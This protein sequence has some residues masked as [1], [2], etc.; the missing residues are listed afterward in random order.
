MIV[1]VCVEIVVVKG[2]MLLLDVVVVAIMF[3][4]QL[5]VNF[6]PV[7]RSKSHIE[8]INPP[9]QNKAINTLK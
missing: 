7:E 5:C 6:T 9:T 8:C 4:E 3:V 2:H 1:I